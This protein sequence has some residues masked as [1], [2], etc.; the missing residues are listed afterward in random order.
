MLLKP[1]KKFWIQSTAAYYAAAGA[2]TPVSVNATGTLLVSTTATTIN[3]TGITVAAGTNS[4][5]VLTVMV[6]QNV[7]TPSTISA[8]W[9]SGG[10]NQTMT[11]LASSFSTGVRGAVVFGLRAPTTGNKTLAITLDVATDLYVCAIAFDHVSQTSDAT[12]FPVAGRVGSTAAT[13]SSTITIPSNSNDYCVSVTS[14][15]SGNTRTANSDT[16]L[17]FSN[18]GATNNA[19][20]QYGVGATSKVMTVTINTGSAPWFTAGVDVAHQ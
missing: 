10:S 4:A 17:Y 18:A 3:Y 20:A 12:A 19:E 11:Q 5:L 15:P 1:K 9:D 14:I 2:I 13:G 8:V 7:G 16:E 6:D